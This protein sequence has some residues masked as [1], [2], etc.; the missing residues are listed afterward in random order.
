[1][2]VTRIGT[3][4]VLSAV[5]LVSLFLPWNIFPALIVL[6][7][8]LA[9]WEWSSL[10]SISNLYSRVFYVLCIVSSLLLLLIFQT[11][12]LPRAFE[13]ALAV[14][15]FWVLL[16]PLLI[17]F[18]STTGLF[19]SK[20]FS[21]ATSAVILLSTAS[22]LIWLSVQNNGAWLVLMLVLIVT[23]A[24]SSAYFAGKKYGKT[25]LAPNISPGKTFEGF[26]G[27]ISL[28]LFFA[29]LLCLTLNFE[30]Q[31]KIA[32]VFVILA[33]SLFS[34]CGDLLESAIKRSH[35]VKDSGTILPGHGGILDR[36]DGLCAATPCFV[37]GLL[38]FGISSI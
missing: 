16:L 15:L 30:P 13:F 28:N 38:L 2:L 20:S 7:L 19:R 36:V 18:P 4:L 11:H 29:L 3:A 26:F 23:I 1:M 10:A 17:K 37:L 12:L 32:L 8:S 24:D 22:G 5:F 21:I 35:G 14:F 27:G 9:A 25:P 6:I 33:T 34:V 31:K